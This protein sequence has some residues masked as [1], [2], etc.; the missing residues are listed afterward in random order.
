MDLIED[1]ARIFPRGPGWESARF[2]ER[3]RFVANPADE[4]IVAD[5]PEPTE[6]AFTGVKF[7]GQVPLEPHQVR[8]LLVV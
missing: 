5:V 2:G 7:S 8:M 1:L 3:V 6:D 4:P